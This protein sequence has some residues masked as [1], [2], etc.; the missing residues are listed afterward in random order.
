MKK[1]LELAF[2]KSTKGT[3]VYENADYNVSFYLPKL[4][5]DNPA[6]APPKTLKLTIEAGE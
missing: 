3:H 5:L 1:T 2:K 6:Q 4:M